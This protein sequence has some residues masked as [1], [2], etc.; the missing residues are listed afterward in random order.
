MMVS[1]ISLYQYKVLIYYILR[2]IISCALLFPAFYYFLRFIVSYVLLIL[3]LLFRLP[4][5]S[6]VFTGPSWHVASGPS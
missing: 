4:S 3:V 5:V 2:F 6:R 1:G